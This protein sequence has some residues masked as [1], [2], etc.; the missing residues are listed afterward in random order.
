MALTQ[1]SNDNVIY[2]TVT[3]TSPAWTL[4]SGDGTKT[5][6]Y[7]VTDGAGRQTTVSDT[8][9]LVT[10]QVVSYQFGR[11]EVPAGHQRWRRRLEAPTFDDS[12]WP[13][14]QGAFGSGGACALQNDG[15]RHTTWQTNTDMLVRRHIA[16]APGTTGVQVWVAID[17]D[18]TAIYWNGTQIGGP[19][20]HE[21]CPTLDS[22]AF[23]VS[24]GLV[25]ADN[26]LAIRARDRGVRPTLMPG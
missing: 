6:W 5:V 21:N 23:A 13:S 2:S 20:V 25:T 4:L 14:G 8:I 18:I 22:R 11:L 1:A 24:P 12:A 15:S 16:L 10:N 9:S 17:N 19:S 7:R 3:G 26:V